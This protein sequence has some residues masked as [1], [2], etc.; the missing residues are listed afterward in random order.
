MTTVNAAASLLNYY[1][2][3]IKSPENS[4]VASKVTNW[5]TKLSKIVLKS[6]HFG[7]N[8]YFPKN[9]W[10][11]IIPKLIIIIKLLQPSR[12]NPVISAYNQINGIFNYNRTPLAIIG[13]LVGI[14]NRLNN[15]GS[16]DYNTT[17]ALYIGPVMQRYWNY[18]CY[19]PA[20]N[21]KQISNTVAFP[22][23]IVT[24][25]KLPAPI[26]SLL[27]SKTSWMN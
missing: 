15:H 16:W 25:I 12:F 21:S 26:D 20:N 13:G 19:V 24:C 1:A 10:G 6:A 5:T 17:E 18:T 27:S 14:Y 2:L 22:P 8:P 23:T 4:S 3:T 9:T 11:L 7:A